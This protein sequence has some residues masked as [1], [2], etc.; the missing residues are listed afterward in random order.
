MFGSVKSN[1]SQESQKRPDENPFDFDDFKSKISGENRGSLESQQPQERVSE[2]SKKEDINFSMFGSVKSD[3]S[4]GSQSQFSKTQNIENLE[5]QQPQERVSE[6][7]KKEDI[8]F[9][10]FGSVKS[11]K[12]NGSQSQFSKPK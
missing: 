4:N 3:K 5:S 2:K 6:K 1:M 10:M 7:S 8:N 12:S 11:D 9:S